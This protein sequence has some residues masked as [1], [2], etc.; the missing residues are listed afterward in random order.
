MSSVVSTPIPIQTV[1][2]RRAVA[3]LPLI[4]CWLNV[5]AAAAIQAATIPGRVYGLSFITEQ[6]LR[7]FNISR[8]T[9]GTVDFCATVVTAVLCVGFGTILT[10]AGTRPTYLVCMIGLGAA[11]AL[12]TVV[13]GTV[14]LFGAIALARVLGQGMLALVS[15]SLVGKSFPRKVVLVMAVYSIVVAL[16][17]VAAVQFIK[18]GMSPTGLH[19]SWREAWLL[20]AAVLVF[21]VTPF[22][23]FTISEPRVPRDAPPMEAVVRAKDGS[24]TENAYQDPDARRGKG[25]APE[26]NLWQAM[27]SP[28]FILF[29]LSCLVTGTANAGIALFNESLLKDRGFSRDVFFDS[30]TV[31]V[32]GVAAFKLV[33]AWLCQRWSMRMMSGLCMLLYATTS[34]AVPFLET[35]NQVYVWS[36]GKAL[37]LSVH[38]VIYYA[39]W[40]YAFGR[41][42]LAQ[43]QGAAHVLTVTASG[44][45]PVIFGICRDQLG[46]YDPC[47]YVTAVC[48]FAIG[49]AMLCVP[50]PCAER[51]PEDKVT[52]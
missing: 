11:T 32:V 44:L 6:L 49:A 21:G 46:T 40:S 13:N 19:L 28:V 36:I 30:L 14:L 48:S 34:V 10:R 24:E 31:G 18:Y 41:R 15:T 7:D 23:F 29:G 3:E 16:M 47:M 52:A 2:V 35:T 27:R 4:A 33:G 37:A 25:V 8:T 43:I 22:G 39:I 45:G 9:F 20:L 12:L 42:D 5:L 1:P 51:P 38:T 26:L 50:V 17:Y